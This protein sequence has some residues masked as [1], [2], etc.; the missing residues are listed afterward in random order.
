[1]YTPRGKSVSARAIEAPVQF[2]SESFEAEG[3]E[4]ERLDRALKR[5]YAGSSWSEVRRLID[6]GKVWVGD[7]VVR[8][9]D[10]PIRPGQ[11]LRLEMTAPRGKVGRVEGDSLV[12]Y[13]DAQVIVVRK[14]EGISS[15]EHEGED[16]SVE[17]RVQHWL[18]DRERKRVAPLGVVH[19]LDK[20][21]SGLMV[22]AR[23]P[24]AKVFLKEQFRAHS[25]GRQ[26]LAL[27]NGEVQPGKLEFRLVRDRGDGLRGV[28]TDPRRGRYSATHVRVMERLRGCCLVQCKL[29]TGR[30]HQIRIHLAHVGHPIVGE[31]LYYKGL[32]VPLLSAPRVM[33][34][35]AT[36]SFDHPGHRGRLSFEEPLP[37]AFLDFLA[38]RRR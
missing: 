15:I 11:L 10:A 4:T 17:Q 1:M 28:A 34:H 6:S 31:T 27:A 35:A 19:R 3:E 26:Y 9:L 8:A 18:S 12:V 21:T 24:A 16:T 5:H 2:K 20:V 37:K 29:E 30:T 22:F 32:D 33:L 38:A 14:P 25:V 36:L 7:V 23:T 13:H